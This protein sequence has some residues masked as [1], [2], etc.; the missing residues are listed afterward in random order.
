MGPFAL[1]SVDFII[2]ELK[3][4]EAEFPADKR[5]HV[6]KRVATRLNEYPPIGKIGGGK[7]GSDG[8]AGESSRA[9]L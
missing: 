7:I 2:A 3:Q 4:V 6:G 1:R 8:H 5:G 9:N